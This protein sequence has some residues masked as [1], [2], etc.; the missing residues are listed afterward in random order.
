MSP[1]LLLSQETSL[2][3]SPRIVFL[4]NKPGQSSSKAE[5]NLTKP[6]KTEL[7]TTPASFIW[8]DCHSQPSTQTLDIKATSCLLTTTYH[9]F[10]DCTTL[11]SNFLFL[12]KHC[13]ILHIS[14][15][16]QY[17]F[18]YWFGCAGPSLLCELFCN[19]AKWG[20]SLVEVH[21]LL[22][23]TAYLVAEH[24]LQSV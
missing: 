17:T 16:F 20:Y 22:M 19:C 4:V 23:V 8:E 9:F 12:I 15:S 5:T 7:L 3:D 24:R 18:I 1:H 13:F 2:L 11:S 14:K 6:D 10:S 21:Q